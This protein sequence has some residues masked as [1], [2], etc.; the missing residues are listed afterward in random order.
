MR[1]IERALVVLSAGLELAAIV[2]DAVDGVALTKR[3][4]S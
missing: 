3:S 2:C 1:A 4:N